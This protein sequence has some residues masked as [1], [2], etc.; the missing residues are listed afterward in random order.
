MSEERP[1]IKLA[2]WHK[3]ASDKFGNDARHWKFICP[4]C[5][6]PQTAQ[7][8]IN[9]GVPEADAKT[10]IAVECIGRWLPNSE[11]AFGE[12]KRK[13]GVPCNYAGYG[14]FKLN[15]V[16]VLFEDGTVFNAFD[17]YEDKKND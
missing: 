15:P 4:I 8:F 3:L 14:L 5:K 12:K 17:F 6:T 16:P 10:S 11:K 1:K 13:K 2:D 9:A 7:D